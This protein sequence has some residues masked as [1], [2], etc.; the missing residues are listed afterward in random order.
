MQCKKQIS[1]QM[2]VVP[3][4]NAAEP[5]LLFFSS[6]VLNLIMYIIPVWRCIYFCYFQELCACDLSICF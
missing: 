3:G 1:D 5:V 4:G 6:F 2:S